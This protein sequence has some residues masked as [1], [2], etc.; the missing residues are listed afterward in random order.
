MILLDTSFLYAYFQERDVHHREALKWAAQL[1]EERGF[2]PVEVFQELVTVITYKVSSKEA[3]RVGQLL[4]AKNSPIQLVASDEELFRKVWLK[5]S[6]LHP[7]ALSFV[8]C[9]LITLAENFSCPIFTFDK[10][11]LA[12]RSHQEVP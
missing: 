3:I 12:M 2:V 10:K 1:D 8:D 6:S 11:I 4:S 7:H 5:F 9:L